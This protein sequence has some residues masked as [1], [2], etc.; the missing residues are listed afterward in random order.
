MDT[1]IVGF[2]DRPEGHAAVDLACEEAR[3]R[4]ARLVVVHSLRG[5]PHT[6]VDEYQRSNDALAELEA[7]LAATHI[8]HEVRRYVRGNTP[9]EDVLAA[10]DE[11]GAHLIVIGYRKRSA[12]GKALLGSSAHQ[13]LMGA[14]CPVLATIEPHV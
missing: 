1:I 4:G 7:Q 6:E 14:R 5:G 11:F 13:I 3:R 9:S 2:V 8:P 10:A 12:T